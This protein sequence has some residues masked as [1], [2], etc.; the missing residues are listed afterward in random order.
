M[1][2]K[3]MYWELNRIFSSPH[4]DS[5]HEMAEAQHELNDAMAEGY[6]PE[7]IILRMKQMV[8]HMEDNGD[9][10]RSKLSLAIKNRF[11]EKTFVKM[12]PYRPFR[13]E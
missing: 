8:A 5:T 3:D 7:K 4:N 1:T 9:P 6:A 13:V 10:Y 11:W 12:I 2:S